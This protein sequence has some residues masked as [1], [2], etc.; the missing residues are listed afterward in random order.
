MSRVGTEYPH[1]QPHGGEDESG[2]RH[3]A[4]RSRWGSVR[5]GRASLIE[6]PLLD[7][8]LD[9]APSS[10]SWSNGTAFARSHRRVNGTAKIIRASRDGSRWTKEMSRNS[11]RS[12][13]FRGDG[14]LEFDRECRQVAPYGR[15][16]ENGDVH[17]LCLFLRRIIRALLAGSMF[18]LSYSWKARLFENPVGLSIHRACL[19]TARGNRHRRRLVSATVI[20]VPALGGDRGVELGRPF[21]ERQPAL[22]V[23]ESPPADSCPSY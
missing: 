20:G 11:H 1:G 6:L 19:R 18:G 17:P 12:L 16:P 3:T 2:A 7:R 14:Q 8:S 5:A 15:L 21:A 9:H 22:C 23:G 13:I 10:D 4:R